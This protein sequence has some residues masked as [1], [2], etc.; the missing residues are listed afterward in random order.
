M[1]MELIEAAVY[2]LNQAKKALEDADKP[3]EMQEG[4]K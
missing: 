3:K 4:E 2:E 1:S